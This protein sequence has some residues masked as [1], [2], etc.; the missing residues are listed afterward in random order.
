M[1]V[2]VHLNHGIDKSY[3]FNFGNRVSKGTIKGILNH[4]QDD[5]A[6]AIY[7]YA[8]LL[9]TVRKIEV[10]AGQKVK[11]GLEADF[12]IGHQGY[13]SEKLV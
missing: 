11:A 8:N 2:L 12:I 13:I 1:K 3:M 10:P 9:E 4:G 7:G 6:Q 5:A